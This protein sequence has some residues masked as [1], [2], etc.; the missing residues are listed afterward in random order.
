MAQAVVRVV[1]EY[2]S[3]HSLP[4]NHLPN[5]CCTP[6]KP[7]WVS[8]VCPHVSSILVVSG[9][10][11]GQ[12]FEPMNWWKLKKQR[13]IN[14]FKS[15]FSSHSHQHS[16]YL[17][18]SIIRSLCTT[19]IFQLIF[20]RCDD[21][22]KNHEYIFSFGRFILKAPLMSLRGLQNERQKGHNNKNNMCW[23]FF[24]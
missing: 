1:D 18:R 24:R 7:Q 12:S 10:V 8:I 20:R 4:A 11:D 9:W 5:C 16:I 17:L 19:E 6:L 21:D 14:E 23:K 13:D 2:V 3:S 22:D 15:N